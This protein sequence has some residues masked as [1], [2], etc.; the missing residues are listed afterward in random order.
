MR[1]G[2]LLLTIAVA[3]GSAN[4]TRAEEWQTLKDE[5]SR[6][7]LFQQ[8][9]VPKNKGDQARAFELIGPF[10]FPTDTTYDKTKNAPRSDALFGVDVS[11]YDG[12]GVR[13]DIMRDQNVRFVYAKA[14]QGVGFKDGQFAEYWAALGALPAEKKLWRGAYHF[15]SSSDDAV[16]QADSFVNFLDQNGGLKPGD[17]PPVLDLEWDIATKN[18][19]D[20]WQQ[21]DPDKIIEM[22]LAWLG[23]VKERTQKVP[24]VYTARSWWHDRGIPEEK[25]SLLK[26]YKIW[27]ADYS[28]SSR[29]V[30][31]PGVP[32]NSAF[33]LWQFSEAALLSTGYGGKLDANVYFGDDLKF[34]NDFQIK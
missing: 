4:L 19:P 26:D 11:H 1:D 24:I 27:I 30:E 15:L 33:N 8:F 6:A 28:S 10:I 5:P 17:L 23:R 7:D 22:V 3:L 16:A 21:H 9:I 14:T 18:G 31:T 34:L 29:A 2:L 13:F 20:R 12:A 25:F 32:N